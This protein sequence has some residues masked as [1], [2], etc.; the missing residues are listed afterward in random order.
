MNWHQRR[1][2]PEGRAFVGGRISTTHFETIILSSTTL[3][4]RRQE[5][6]NDA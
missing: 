5:K 1:R 4:A 6:H 2:R 3:L